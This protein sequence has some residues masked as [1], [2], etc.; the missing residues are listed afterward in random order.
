MT[1]DVVRLLMLIA[2]SGFRVVM[3]IPSSESVRTVPMPEEPFRH[4]NDFVAI[5]FSGIDALQ[6]MLKRLYDVA[7]KTVTVDGLT[8]TLN[9]RSEIECAVITLVTFINSLV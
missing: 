7:F 3:F 1:S 8:T 9:S 5:T 2:S 4:T 6:T